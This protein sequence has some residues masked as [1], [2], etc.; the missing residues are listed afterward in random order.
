VLA[1]DK[2]IQALLADHLQQA[3]AGLADAI[4]WYASYVVLL[5]D[6]QR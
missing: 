4:F 1:R 5:T 3:H 2:N 6:A